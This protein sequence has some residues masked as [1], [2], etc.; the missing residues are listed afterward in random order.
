MGFFGRNKTDEK[1]SK[2]HN[3][4]VSLDGALL[5]FGI[6][7]ISRADSVRSLP[8]RNGGSKRRSHD[9]QAG[10]ITTNGRL[11]PNPGM[12]MDS[13]SSEKS[14]QLLG[15]DGHK[16]KH[17]QPSRS[18]S[19]NSSSRIKTP[20]QP[21]SKAGPPETPRGQEIGVCADASPDLQTNRNR[22]QLKLQKP[23]RKYHRWKVERD[24]GGIQRDR[25]TDTDSMPAP[26][27][28]MSPR[29][30]RSPI[31]SPS[32]FQHITHTQQQEFNTMASTKTQN[33]L[34][35]EFAVHRAAQIG[36]RD[37][38]GIKVAN[39]S[40]RS[41]SSV[42]AAAVP[43][44]TSESSHDSFQSSKNHSPSSSQNFSKVLRTKGSFSM[45]FSD[46]RMPPMPPVSNQQTSAGHNPRSALEDSNRL[47]S[48]N[49]AP[50]TQT[51]ESP[52][53]EGAKVEVALGGQR[54][55]AQTSPS[56][57]AEPVRPPQP[58]TSVGP[59]SGSELAPSS[60]LPAP[61]PPP[62]RNSFPFAS[63]DVAWYAAMGCYHRDGLETVLPSVNEDANGFARFSADSQHATAGTPGFNDIMPFRDS[64]P[65]PISWSQPSS[66]RHHPRSPTP[67]RH[68]HN[69]HGP[70]SKP[71]VLP[72]NVTHWMSPEEQRV[73]MNRSS[74]IGGLFSS[75]AADSDS[76]SDDGLEATITATRTSVDSSQSRS[77]PSS[78]V[79][80]DRF[81]HAQ[82]PGPSS[83]TTHEE[84]IKKPDQDSETSQAKT[85]E[86]ES[87]ANAIR[88]QPAPVQSFP[89]QEDPR[90][91][92][93]GRGTKDAIKLQRL[94][95]PELM[96]MTERVSP[97]S[98]S[99]S[100]TKSSL[101][102][103]DRYYDTK[104]LPQVPE[105]PS[106]MSSRPMS[107][108]SA[109]RDA[110]SSGKPRQRAN[111]T[112]KNVRFE[113]SPEKEDLSPQTQARIAAHSDYYSQIWANLDNLQKSLAKLELEAADYPPSRNEINQVSEVMRATKRLSNTPQ[114]ALSASHRR[115]KSTA[116]SIP[117]S[118]PEDIEPEEEPT[119]L[120]P[121][122]TPPQRGRSKTSPA[123]DPDTSPHLHVT[124][125]VR[126]KSNSAS[127]RLHPP[128]QEIR[129]PAGPRFSVFPPPSM[130]EKTAA[131]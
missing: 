32:N 117:Q 80:S 124:P 44:L 2:N 10:P 7:P 11:T 52:A 102:S 78:P 3:A 114:R 25:N 81:S 51:R 125:P 1:A 76:S 111:T 84:Q 83:S 16:H 108:R 93:P 40:A 62:E 57:C 90:D 39:L 45:P 36:Q 110:Q 46:S 126:S 72:K 4:N 75:W 5:G 29:S 85:T 118:V 115:N 128:R 122:P 64:L 87:A 123:D 53:V 60:P 33:D 24:C 9:V 47:H 127:K 77:Y 43:S 95:I 37:L 66:P 20:T 91:A 131:V 17:K 73:S 106:P 109:L 70:T 121:M 56:G 99:L 27:R 96:K 61:A 34:V 19:R 13:K 6:R 100:P 129:S 30:P 82:R 50:G 42:E 55:A 22:V 120:P 98:S 31:S 101:S 71:N 8:A 65:L 94:H 86:D 26:A 79:P 74:M 28:A 35:V 67:I 130:H 119:A 116:A 89:P 104:P 23:P 58:S 21:S 103:S 38:R 113:D 14:T 12:F 49:V 59:A 107:P 63:K 92:R 69:I 15:V 48:G 41:S 112:G 97:E 54:D 18:H 88:D 105:N 68:L